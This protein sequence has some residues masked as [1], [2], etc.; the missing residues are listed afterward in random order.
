[1]TGQKNNINQNLLPQ[2]LVKDEVTPLVMSTNS[3]ISVMNYLS[4]G[5]QLSLSI[6][7]LGIIIFTKYSNEGSF[8]EFSSSISGLIFIGTFTT[9]IIFSMLITNVYLDYKYRNNINYKEHPIIK[10]TYIF[11]DVVGA[12]LWYIAIVLMRTTESQCFK[13]PDILKIKCSVW[14]LGFIFVIFTAFL[15]TL[16]SIVHVTTFIR[17]KIQKSK[18]KN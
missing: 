8:V 15:W 18:R 5:I 12:T 17:R 16:T 6:A 14:L 13:V 7:Y 4:R 3:Q 11:F 2:N 10:W 9:F 1:M